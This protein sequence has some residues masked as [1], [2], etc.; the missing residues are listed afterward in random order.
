M[1]RQSQFHARE[2]QQEGERERQEAQPIEFAT[3]E[4]LLRHDALHT[5]VPPAVGHRLQESVAR[6]PMRARSWWRRLLGL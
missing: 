1:K 4:Q 2:Q 6:L 5:P 3:P